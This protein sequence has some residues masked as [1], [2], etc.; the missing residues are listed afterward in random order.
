[1]TQNQIRFL[2][3]QELQRANLAKESENIRTNQTKEKETERA[4]KENERLAREKWEYEK[5]GKDPVGQAVRTIKSGL[6]ELSK[7]NAADNPKS[8]GYT[9]VTDPATGKSYEPVSIGG[10]N[11]GA[12]AES[13][14]RQRSEWMKMSKRDFFKYYDSVQNGE[15]KLSPALKE[16]LENVAQTRRYS[17]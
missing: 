9:P 14:N 4:N 2:E 12:T 1:M 10:S 8:V 15:V 11:W 16:L 5:Y 17:L 6:D 13:N 7:G 3:L